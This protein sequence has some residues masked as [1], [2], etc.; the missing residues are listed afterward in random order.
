MPA[1]KSTFFIDYGF[2]Y[3]RTAIIDSIRTDVGGVA[4]NN[5][6][7]ELYGVDL[8]EI[9]PELSWH[10]KADER[11]NLLFTWRH[12]WLFLR[13][14]RFQQ[15]ANNDVFMEDETN[16]SN[17]QR[18]NTIQMLATLQNKTGKLFFRY[19][20]H[21]QQDFWTTSFHQAQVGYSFYLL[22]RK[23]ETE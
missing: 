9:T 16:P 21:W 13:D 14:T 19:R 6:F 23:D 7:A 12:N 11:Y 1:F 5:G 22:G 10:L 15:V 18:Y 3:G 8:F 4:Q 20:F 2:R 17:F